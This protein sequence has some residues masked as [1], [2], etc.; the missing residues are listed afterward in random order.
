[1]G[2]LGEP[3]SRFR[4]WH[5]PLPWLPPGTPRAACRTAR[6]AP[7][8]PRVPHQ[9]GFLAQLHGGNQDD[10]H[11]SDAPRPDRSSMTDVQA[12]ASASELDALRLLA[13]ALAGRDVEL[14]D[15]GADRAAWTDGSTIFLDA[16]ATKMQ[17]LEML[18]VQASLL[19]AGSLARD[20]T[21]ELG[22][23][24]ALARRYLAIEG[25]RA[26]VANENVLPARGRR[27]IDHDLTEL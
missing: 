16:S 27:L 21:R 17:H 23:R 13:A 4:R 15:A 9:A 19:A 8:H 25:H 1:M 3:S 10:R 11:V 12:A 7:P 18:S 6:V 20:V 22:R 14:A 24:P 5:P 2:S 26:L